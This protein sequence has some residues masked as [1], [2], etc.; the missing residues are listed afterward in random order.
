MN[1]LRRDNVGNEVRVVSSRKKYR[2]ESKKRIFRKKLVY[3]FVVA[4]VITLTG[5]LVY[6]LQYPSNQALPDQTLQHKAVIVDQLSS[7]HPNATF[8]QTARTILNEAGFTVE[9]HQWI[10]LSFY[11]N[12]PKK[13]SDLIIFRVHSAINLESDQLVFFT[14][15]PFDNNKA[16]TT[17]LSD[18]L[19]DRIVRAR[20][21]VD[22]PW[23]F[24]ITP[25]FI[26]DSNERFDNTIIVMM[27]CDGLTEGYTSMAEA[28]INKGA[29][30]YIGW[31]GPVNAPHTDQATI[32]L[33]QHLI[34]EKQTIEKAVTE[35]MNEVGVDPE[36]HSAL[37]F[38]PAE[39]ASYSILNNASNI[40]A[41]VTY[42]PCYACASPLNM[43]KKHVRRVDTPKLARNLPEHTLE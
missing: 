30:V 23:Y 14:T 11:R 20:V 27:G 21:D 29:K 3:G 2:K 19:N 10:D 38:Y 35:T 7:T 22:T 41:Q 24:G 43:G 32:R 40:Q 31:N 13:D 12:L 9:Y 5:F 16:S 17:Y 36:Y 25:Q 26:T 34:G 33:L 39:S 37:S 15:E 18:V 6:S 1:I 42:T 8:W 28:F 4:A